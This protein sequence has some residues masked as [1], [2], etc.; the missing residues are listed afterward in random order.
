MKYNYFIPCNYKEDLYTNL[1]NFS[2]FL[3]VIHE[4]VFP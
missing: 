4:M 1:F 3:L 2:Y